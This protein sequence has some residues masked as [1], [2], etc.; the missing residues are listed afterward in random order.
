VAGEARRAVQTWH[1]TDRQVRGRIMAALRGSAAAIPRSDL[2]VVAVDPEQAGRCLASLLADGL[3]V[4]V[5]PEH[6]GLPD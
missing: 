3:A 5:G 6:V 2:A 4:P 1:G